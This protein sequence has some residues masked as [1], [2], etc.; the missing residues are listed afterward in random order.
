[1]LSVTLSPIINPSFIIRHDCILHTATML[2]KNKCSFHIVD[3]HWKL[4]NKLFH[5][6]SKVRHCWTNKCSRRRSKKVGRT[7][8]WLV[9]QSH[10]I[11]LH[12]MFAGF[13]RKRE[14]HRG[15]GICLTI[16]LLWHR[17]NIC[18][19]TCFYRLKLRSKE[20]ILFVLIHW[21]DLPTLTALSPLD[22]FLEFIS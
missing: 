10:E 3:K 5:D 13:G 12:N 4:L 16:L 22:L 2:L 8:K 21:M 1:M 20:S 6:I 7:C 15:N 14:C 17:M 19:F 9:Y 11:F 18:K